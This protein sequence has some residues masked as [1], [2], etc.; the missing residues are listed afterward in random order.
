MKTGADWDANA[1]L[2]SMSKVKLR[3]LQAAATAMLDGSNVEIIRG[4]D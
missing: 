3:D 2:L 4:R 1:L